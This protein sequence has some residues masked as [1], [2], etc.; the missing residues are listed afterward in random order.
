MTNWERQMAKQLPLRMAINGLSVGL[1]S[2]YY[3][4]RHNEI[5]RVLRMKFSVD[6]IVNV[7]ARGA[8]AFVVSDLCTRKLF[9]NHMRIKE[10]KVATNEVKKVMT[11]MPNAKTL[12][13]PQ[14]KPNSYFYV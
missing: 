9:V 8:L 5:N 2:F 10:H 3:L 12:I 13:A 11:T 6:M 7:G 1:F 4:S 14:D